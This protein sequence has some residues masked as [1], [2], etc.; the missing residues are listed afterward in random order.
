MM[1]PVPQFH[2]HSANEYIKQINALGTVLLQCIHWQD[3]DTYK[4]ETV[5]QPES[6]EPRETGLLSVEGNQRVTS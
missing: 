4:Q 6:R 2:M 5:N 1:L 3:G